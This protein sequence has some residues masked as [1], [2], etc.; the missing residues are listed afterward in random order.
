[1]SNSSFKKY[2]VHLVVGRYGSEVEIVVSVWEEEHVE[3]VIE[4]LYADRAYVSYYEEINN[5]DGN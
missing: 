4:E 3:Y 2:R 5:D 1:M